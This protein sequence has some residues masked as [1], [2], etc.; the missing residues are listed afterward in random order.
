MKRPRPNPV[1]F[2]QAIGHT[3]IDRDTDHESNK[4]NSFLGTEGAGEGCF[5]LD[6]VPVSE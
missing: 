5:F 4:Q 2:S 3:H 6:G 1:I